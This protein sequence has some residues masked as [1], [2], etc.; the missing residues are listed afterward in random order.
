MSRRYDRLYVRLPVD[1]VGVSPSGSFEQPGSVV[2]LSKGG[3]RIQTDRRLIQGQ[4]LEVFL[5][6][7]AEPFASCRVVWTHTRGCALP[8]EAG[9]EI[10]EPALASS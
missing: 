10:C 1:L 3:L 5:R 7:V 6:G 9:L 4:V 8:C 2:D